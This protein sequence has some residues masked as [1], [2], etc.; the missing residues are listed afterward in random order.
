MALTPFFLFSPSYLHLV[1]SSPSAAARNYEAAASMAREEKELADAGTYLQKS[2]QCHRENG[3]PD[4]AA[5][6]LSRAGKSVF[7][8]LFSLPLCLPPLIS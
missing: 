1:L 3:N 6:I 5:D 4:K 2:A 8:S 7:S